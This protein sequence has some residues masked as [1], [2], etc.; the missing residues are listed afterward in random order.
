ME[1]LLTLFPKNHWKYYIVIIITVVLVPQMVY[2]SGTIFSP[3]MVIP[4]LC[5]IASWFTVPAGL[6][7]LFLIGVKWLRTSHSY[8]PT[9]KIRQAVLS[10]ILPLLGYASFFMGRKMVL[11]IEEYARIQT[12][13]ALIKQVENFRNIQGFYPKSI[14][15]LKLNRDLAEQLNKT[16][17]RYEL[18]NTT[19]IVS[20]MLGGY[21]LFDYYRFVYSPDG[22]NI[23]FKNNRA[24][25]QYSISQTNWWVYREID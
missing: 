22:K 20:F 13:N 25:S 15:A 3:L 11:T 12:S 17:I 2:L 7:Q 6:I 24:I 16:Q 14:E 23:F 21:F 9:F 19:Y 5:G 1:S 10:V 8:Y 4:I 18:N